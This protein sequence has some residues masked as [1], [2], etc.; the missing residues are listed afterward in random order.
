M[1]VGSKKEAVCTN[2][3]SEPTSISAEAIVPDGTYPFSRFN[4]VKQALLD[5][6]TLKC[7]IQAD[8][9][10]QSM[11]ERSFVIAYHTRSENPSAVAGAPKP[12][13]AWNMVD[14]DHFLGRKNATGCKNCEKKTFL[15]STAPLEVYS[16]MT[17]DD[18]KVFKIHQ[19]YVVKTNDDIQPYI[20][21]QLPED[22]LTLHV[23]Q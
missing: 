12:I 20:F 15:Y 11:I 18:I 5:K 17:T 21:N 16:S 7:Y 10:T 6:D 13:R 23:H 1:D 8:I 22:K 4:D 2:T 3:T 19:K 9:E 14:T